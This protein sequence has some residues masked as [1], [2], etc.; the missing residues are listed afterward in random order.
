MIPHTKRGIVPVVALQQGNDR[1]ALSQSAQRQT[2]AERFGVS[3][4]VYGPSAVPAAMQALEIDL[5]NYLNSA[6]SGLY[7]TSIHH[8]EPSPMPPAT[9]RTKVFISYAHKDE[10]WRETMRKTLKSLERKG[11]L[12]VWDDRRLRTGDAWRNE[13]ETALSGCGIAILLVTLD[14]LNSDFINDVELA[15]IFERHEKEGVWICPILIGPCDWEGEEQLKAKQMKLCKGKAFKL[16]SEA[17]QEEAFAEIAKE[18]RKRLD[19]TGK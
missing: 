17:E 14:F 5:L 1:H 16:A 2:F 15:Q 10:Q 18:I 3:L 7:H 19:S 4:F 6:L 8:E 11:Q 13:I 12:D 9:N